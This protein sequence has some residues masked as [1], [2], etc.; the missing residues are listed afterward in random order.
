MR[1]SGDWELECDSDTGKCKIRYYSLEG[2]SSFRFDGDGY[3]EGEEVGI[4]NKSLS[5]C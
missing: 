1:K 2:R 3:K 5:Q 4:N